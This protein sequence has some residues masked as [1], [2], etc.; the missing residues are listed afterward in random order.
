MQVHQASMRPSSLSGLLP[1]QN[2]FKP[3]AAHSSRIACTMHRGYVMCNHV[4]VRPA[5]HVLVI[6]DITLYCNRSLMM[7]GNCVETL[8][9]A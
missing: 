1:P 4:R 5:A 3:P 7:Y 6:A 2:A 9:S 8:S